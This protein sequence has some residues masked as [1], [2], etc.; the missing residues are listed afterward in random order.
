MSRLLLPR[1][2]SSSQPVLG[3]PGGVLRGVDHI[4]GRMVQVRIQRVHVLRGQLGWLPLAPCWPVLAATSA[5][6]ADA[7]EEFFAR[8]MVFVWR[9][10]PFRIWGRSWADRAFKAT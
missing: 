5:S 8:D 7:R 10:L 3:S 4:V 6:G 9:L 1:Q 2:Y